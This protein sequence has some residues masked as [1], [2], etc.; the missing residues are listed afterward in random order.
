[1]HQ[2]RVIGINLNVAPG[3]AVQELPVHENHWDIYGCLGVFS[4][5]ISVDSKVFIGSA[6]WK[7]VTWLNQING[8]F[9]HA[10][11]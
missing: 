9:N 4:A 11:Q 7:I 3:N 6:E 1:L 5:S 2:L 10:I 8:F